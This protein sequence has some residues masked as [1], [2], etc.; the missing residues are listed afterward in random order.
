M[1]KTPK[2]W[3]SNSLISKVISGLLT[4]LSWLYYLGFKAHRFFNRPSK[5]QVKTICIGNLTAGGSG[6]TPT[7]ITIGK[8][9]KKN[10][11]NFAYLSRGYKGSSRDFKE[12]LPNSN[13]LKSG[14]EP[15]LLSKIAPTFTSKNRIKGLKQLSKKYELIIID[16][17]MQNPHINYD[18]KILVVDSK[19]GFGNQKLLPAGPLRESLKS[20]IKK[21]DLIIMIGS[22][23]ELI[24]T[25]KHYSDTKIIQANIKAL[26]LKEFMN[27][28]LIAFCGLAYPEKFFSFLRASNLDLIKTKSFA[29]HH[30]YSND[31]LDDLIQLAKDK[32]A[33][34]ITTKK[35]WIRM[36]KQYQEK[37]SYLDIELE[38]SDQQS[39]L[40]EINF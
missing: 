39:I 30:L 22:S 27:H 21:A 33:K 2:F 29:D 26:N 17:G 20:G 8:L 10:N 28:R 34:L 16:D 14:D 15:I 7:A 13:P 18:K 25:I 24:K 36:P 38:L 5:S 1:I 31:Q 23:Q 6:K 9:L 11:I 35:D 3:T 32:K 12:I 40:K 19:I 4:P 37:I